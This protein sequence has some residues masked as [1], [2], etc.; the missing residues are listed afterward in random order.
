MKRRQ[1]IALLGGAA[2]WPLIARAQQSNR[3]RRI[4][5]L[6]TGVQTEPTLRSYVAA[7]AQALRNLGWLDGQNLRIDYRWNTGSAEQACAYAAELVALSPDVIIAASTT[8]LRAVQAANS[9]MATVFVQVSDPVAQGFVSNLA[10]PGGNITGFSAYEFSMGGKWLDLLKQ[11]APNVTRVAVMFNPDTS[12]QSKLFLSSIQAAA[13][14]FGME[15]VPSP[16]RNVADIR[17]TIEDFSRQPNGGLLLPTDTFTRLSGKLIVELAAR[18]RL[19]AISAHPEFVGEGGLIHYGF[20][21][22]E[23]FR[24]AASYV[25]RILKGAKPGELPIQQPTKFILAIN[26]RTAKALDLD[27]PLRLQQLADEVIE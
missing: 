4:G 27:V 5:L 7:F 13:P 22:I 20:D 21:G 19:P 6:M 10:R 9:T 23:A 25:D 24:Q 16:V 15:V 11:I 12:P 17:Q 2:A 1:F 26:L 8:N 14:P 18:Y 3:A